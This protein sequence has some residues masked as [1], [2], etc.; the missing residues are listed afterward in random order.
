MTIT[1]S[2]ER[3][4][5]RKAARRRLALAGAKGLLGTDFPI[6]VQMIPMR[7][8]N[9]ACAYCNEYDK[10]SDPVPTKEML[11]RIDH[12]A[13]LGTRIISFSGGEPLLHPDV[14]ELYA[15]IKSHG[16]FAE[17]LTNGYL[18]SPER[19]ERL[20][21]VGLDR[22]QISVD[23]VKPDDVSKKSLKVL[24]R[25]LVHLA[26]HADFDVNINSVVG[27]GV[28]N[29]RDALEVTRRAR[30]LGFSSTVGVIH[31]ESGQLKPLPPEEREV[32][33]EIQGLTKGLGF[34]PFVGF[35]ESLV[36][37]KP[38]DWKCRAGARY[39]YICEQ[40]LV[41]YCS[42]QRGSP[43]VPLLEYTKADIR[44]EFDTKKSCAPL[45]T[46]SCV[47]AIAPIDAWRGPQKGVAQFDRPSSQDEGLVE[48]GAGPGTR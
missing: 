37:G 27:G 41:H 47:H 17:L 45:C 15:R 48:I 6:L 9:L 35:K 24:D 8:C 12:L 40:G 5:K 11:A 29:A 42:Q 26:E 39:L 14:D 46:I 7:R 10:V 28:K 13:G 19:I 36:N 3:L 32:Y 33:Y 23:N 30:E 22:L 44:R 31:D 4:K 21:R 38:Y 1:T 20:N 2:P 16:I 34:G 25:K 43:G 18:L